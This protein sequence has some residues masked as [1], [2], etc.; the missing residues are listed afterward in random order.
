[1]YSKILGKDYNVKNFILFAASAALALTAYIPMF[2][3]MVDRWM[4]AES[5]YGHGILIPVI[6]LYFVWR[7]KHMLAAAPK[8]NDMT[9]LFIVS[10]GLLVHLAS[11]ALRIYFLSGFS[12]VLVLYGLVLFFFGRE[13]SKNLVFPIFFLFAMI[14]L[15][16]VLIGTLTVKLKLAVAE[17]ATLVLNNIGFPS[18]R[19][20]SVIMMPTSKILVGA[21]CSGL[22]SLISLLT[23]GL[24]FA[25]AMKTSVIKKG[26]LFL[27]SVPIALGTNVVRVTMLAIVNDLYGEKAASGFFHDLTG[28]IMFGIAFI[29]LIGVNKLLDTKV[30]IGEVLNDA[31]K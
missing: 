9:G 3:W 25:F 7:R 31:S 22:R 23:L 8:S 2:K 28:F 27:S 11:S 13:F 17:A 16:L 14:P 21:P 30:K 10:A 6:S 5:Y 12:F 1:M 19:D 29:G 15:P 24:V 18:A 4:A 20:G 26:I